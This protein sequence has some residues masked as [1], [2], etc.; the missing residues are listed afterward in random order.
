LS[1]AASAR[2]DPAVLV[3][4]HV[5]LYD[6]FAAGAFLD[7]AAANFAAAARA[8]RLPADTPGMLL[9]AESQGVDAF[10]QLANGSRPA[11]PWR[12]EPTAEPVSLLASG[13]AGPPLALVAGRQIVTAEGL[14]VLALGTRARF[15]DGQPARDALAAV[16][17]TGALAV[18]PWAVGKWTGRRGA[19]IQELL[20]DLL[21]AR[22]YAGDNGGRLAWWPRPRLL[23]QA[24]RC[25][26]PVLPGS[27]PLPL[28]AEVSKPGRYG[29]VAEVNLD[30]RGPFAPLK[31]WLDAQTTSP[32]PYGRLE[33]PLV[34]VGHQIAM[35]VR[36]RGRR[37]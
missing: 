31:Q 5:H 26:R 8:L 17:A 30:R 16:L 18:L 25:G 28:P 32:R 15:A 13:P 21:T 27:D 20:Q 37:R 35:Q 12:L 34:F 10:S 19:L 2:A 36:K 9:L 1:T 23:A 3:D 33:R 11:A 29:F 7:A 4:A 6:G 22:L 24:E 14:E